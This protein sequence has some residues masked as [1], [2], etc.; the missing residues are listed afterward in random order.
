LIKDKRVANGRYR[1]L[2]V[3]ALSSL[4]VVLAIFASQLDLTEEPAWLANLTPA[5]HF[6]VH[7]LFFL[8]GSVFGACVALVAIKAFPKLVKYRRRPKAMSTS[9]GARYP[10]A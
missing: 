9:E 6:L 5:E 8:C 3:I 4:A 2:V 7:V 10:P 1:W